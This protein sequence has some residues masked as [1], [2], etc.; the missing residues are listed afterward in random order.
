MIIR[1]AYYWVSRFSP[2]SRILNR[3]QGFG[4]WRFPRPHEKSGGNFLTWVPQRVKVCRGH[5]TEHCKLSCWNRYQTMDKSWNSLKLSLKKWFN[6]HVTV[7]PHFP[8]SSSFF[9][10]SAISFLP[11]EGNQNVFY[12]A[13]SINPTA[14]LQ[15]CN[16]FITR[17]RNNAKNNY[18][19]PRICLP[20]RPSAR[21][22]QLGSPWTDFREI[23][24]LTVFQKYL[25]KIQ[26]SLPAALR[27]DQRTFTKMF[28]L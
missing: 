2:T 17:V 28:I 14:V 11:L 9:L 23:W 7:K 26:A 25:E 27:E 6:N 8:F 10:Y 22:T 13:K 18:L 4:N 16:R 15:L 24:Y 5:S 12:S 20:V 3:T 19:L 21:M 1:P